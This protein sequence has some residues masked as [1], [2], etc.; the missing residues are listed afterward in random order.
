MIRGIY[1]N[2][3]KYHQLLSVDEIAAACHLS[4]QKVR[5]LI[6][7]GLLSPA[8]GY[9]DTVELSDLLWF[10]INNS[11]V[12]P[13]SLL[14]PRT[15]KIL[16]ISDDEATFLKNEETI[17]RICRSF[18][19]TS[20]LVV[21]ESALMGPPADMTILTLRPD[22]A[23]IIVSAYNQKI[24]TT[25]DLLASQATIK[26]IVL[27]DRTTKLASDTGLVSLPA[28][29]LLHSSTTAEVLNDRLQALFTR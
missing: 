16:F 9:S 26:T 15:G 21:V 13:A 17:D 14:P 3:C 23:V 24:K 20:S 19:Q 2:S 29:I 27:V 10:L 5:Q 28:D 11:M 1:Y 22:V 4:S 25:L 7:A 12:I 6:T 18:V 8:P